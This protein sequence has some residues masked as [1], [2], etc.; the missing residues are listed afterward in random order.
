MRKYAEGDVVKPIRTHTFNGLKYKI[1]FGE[2]DGLC[3]TCKKEREIIIS[4]D[5]SKF[6]GLETVIHESLHACNWRASEKSVERT[7]RDIARF[8]RRIYKISSPP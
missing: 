3:D 2:F 4:A 6:T 5:L 7:A 8:L 1:T